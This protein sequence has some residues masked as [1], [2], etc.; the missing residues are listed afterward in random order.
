LRARGAVSLACTDSVATVFLM[1]AL[2]ALRRRYPGIMVRMV[3]STQLSN[4]TRR[5][6][7]LA[8]RSVRPEAPD[9]IV[10]HLGQRTL[11]LYATR[12][13]LDARGLPEAGTGL[14][15]H[16][17]VV[18]DRS[19]GRYSRDVLCGE[20]ARGAHMALEANTG[21]ML[22]PPSPRGWASARSQPTSRGAFALRV[23]PERPEPL[24]CGS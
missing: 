8:V 16:D 19:F 23:W 14:A 17:I 3:A 15:G 4:L 2:G 5:E 1:P 20:P 22:T 10:R 13:Y 21:M 6:A 7:D 11:G 18:Y 9:L 12:E 24:R